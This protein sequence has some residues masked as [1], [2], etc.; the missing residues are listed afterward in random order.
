MR[1]F[2]WLVAALA[3]YRISHMVALE[4]GPYDLFTLA[5]TLTGERYGPRSWQF[6][7]VNCVLCL[8]F[9]LALPVALLLRPRGITQFILDWLGLAGAVMVAHKKIQGK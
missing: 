8:S 3:V 7:G 2:D 5:R 6:E 9:W 1:I 4:R